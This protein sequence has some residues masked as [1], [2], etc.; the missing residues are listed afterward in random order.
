MLNADYVFI[1]AEWPHAQCA[2]LHELWKTH[3][4]QLHSQR[5]HIANLMPQIH[6][7]RPC[8]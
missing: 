8:R 6:T 4:T 3:D 2:K 7:H 1:C 5:T